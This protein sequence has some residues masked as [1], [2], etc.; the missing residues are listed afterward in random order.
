MFR[1]L[2]GMLSSADVEFI[3]IGGLAAIAHGTSRATFDVDVVY[4]R[5]PEKTLPHH[6]D[7]IR[8]HIICIR[9]R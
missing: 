6:S 4:S 8:E 9:G 2:L 3:L 1:D 5:A 7:R